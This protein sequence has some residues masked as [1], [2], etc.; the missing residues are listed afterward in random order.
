MAR[1]VG[2]PTASLPRV[3]RSVKSLSRCGGAVVDP[4]TPVLIGAGQLSTGSTEARR[5]S[6]RST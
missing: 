3:D 6:S 1:I 2:A 5:R 4:R